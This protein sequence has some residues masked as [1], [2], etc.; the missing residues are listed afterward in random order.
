MFRDERPARIARAAAALAVLA[1]T[2]VAAAGA[3]TVTVSGTV[4]LPD[5]GAATGIAVTAWSAGGET[6]TTTDGTGA[7]NLNIP[8][9]FLVLLFRPDPATGLAIR[10]YEFEEVSAGLTLDVTLEQ[11]FRIAGTVRDPGGGVSAERFVHFEPLD[12]PSRPGEVLTLSADAGDGSFSAVLAPGVYWLSVE[13]PEPYF[14]PYIPVDLRHGEM[15]GVE[16][17]LSA[18]PRSWVPE[19]PPDPAR[20]TIGRDR[21]AMGRVTITGAA[22]SV[23]PLA[24]V[25]VTN[26]DTG[27]RAWTDADDQGGFTTL[28]AVAQGASVAVQATAPHR[29]VP[30]PPQDPSG[31]L[32]D[33][34]STL[35]PVP[36]PTPVN[37]GL[38]VAASAG[39]AYARNPETGEERAGG[40]L[41]LSGTLSGQSAADGTIPVST[42]QPAH[43]QGELVLR[44]PA[45]TGDLDPGAVTVQVAGGMLGA[46]LDGRGRQIPLGRANESTLLTPTG[47]PIEDERR[48]AAAPLETAL[49]V[50]EFQRTGA[51]ELR[52]PVEGWLTPGSNV[53][54]G[55]YRPIVTVMVDGPFGTEGWPAGGLPGAGEPVRFLWLPPVRVGPAPASRRLTTMLFAGHASQG[56]R[57]ALAREDT[58]H[59]ALS[60]RVVSQGAPYVL[61]PRDRRT[62]ELRHYLLAPFVPVSGHTDRAIP[63]PPLA[64]FALP[65]GTVTVT[66]HEPGGGVRTLGP[67]RFLAAAAVTETSPSGEELNFG[68][69]QLDNLLML[70]PEGGEFDTT[71]PEYGHHVITVEG[72][73]PDRWGGSDT[74]GGTFDVWVAEPLQLRPGVLPGTPL[75]VGDTFNP[76]LQVLPGL[77]AE[78]S[79]RFTLAPGSDATNLRTWTVSGTANRFGYFDGGAGGIV[80]DAPGE[81][82]VDISARYTAPGGTVYMGTAA[83]GGVVM[84]PADEAHLVAHGRRGVD[85]QRSI[86][87][88]WFVSRRDLDIPGGAVCHTFNTYFT[89]DILWSRDEDA[90]WGG[91]ALMVAATVQDPTGTIE[92][93]IRNRLASQDFEFEGQ[94]RLNAGEL[95]LFIATGDGGPPVFHPDG[96]VQ[97]AY[98]YRYSERPGVRVRESVSE[99]IEGADYWRLNSQYDGQYGVGSLGDLPGDFKFQYVGTVFRDLEEGTTEYGGHGSLWVHL[100]PDDAVGSRA[101]PP[102]PEDGN[103]GWT[104]EGGPIMTLG[105]ERVDLFILPTGVGPGSILEVGDRFRFAGHIA[106]ALPSRVSVVITAPSGA[107]RSITGTANRVGYFAGPDGGFVVDEPGVWTVDVKAW[108]EGR[109]SGGRVV[110]PYPSG[111]VLGAAQGRFVVYVVQ[112]GSAPITFLDPAQGFLPVTG[113]STVVPVR[114]LAM[115]TGAGGT[116][117]LTVSMPGF[118]LEHRTLALDG[119]VFGA[120]YDPVSLAQ[121]FP[122]LDLVGREPGR[123]GLADTVRITMLA[124]GGSRFQAG[125]IL[126]RGEEI[127]LPQTILPNP[128]HGVEEGPRTA[129]GAG[130]GF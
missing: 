64:G 73:V 24:R 36:A 105:G 2:A 35:I 92:Q 49:D 18:T 78:V 31:S 25:I 9:G 7:Y 54:G 6:A 57:G 82:R 77:P 16:L 28:L 102:F 108:H 47:F 52:A 99:D 22:G 128:S 32:H 1:W 66:I 129:N 8:P 40:E 19:R 38:P 23:P 100:P 83:W 79:I 74:L 75:E 123:P 118:L 58:G 80:P 106:P 65:G 122:N 59:W 90:E 76:T 5:G 88:A 33:I 11:G 121:T 15:T 113:D 126:L 91:D 111:S 85:C 60:T 70:L 93:R 42:A 87:S 3:D 30:I 45:V 34:P 115:A 4:T 14:T 29:F 116:G 101:M 61:E 17:P 43:L 53:P 107:S 103:D 26:L 130:G 20:I 37:G 127:I 46:F 97:I 110:E 95:P 89:G 81:Y 51:H 120:A 12:G 96:V 27:A 50:G 112:P 44:G 72:T 84:T 69:T 119:P 56:V 124:G 94:E 86:P 125:S 114:A 68:C 55:T 117:D 67:A 41:I 109:C 63:P 98:A 39:F 10:R 71:F 13:N 62:G 104:T 21:D 48:M